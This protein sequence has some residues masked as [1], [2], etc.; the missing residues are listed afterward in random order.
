MLVPKSRCC[1]NFS[2]GIPVQKIPRIPGTGIVSYT[3]YLSIEQQFYADLKKVYFMGSGIEPEVMR[4]HKRD[5][6]IG[7]VTYLLIKIVIFSVKKY[8]FRSF[9]LWNWKSFTCF[10]FYE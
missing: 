6:Q 1:D 7:H 10:K 5:I 9:F 2:P 8:T 3:C 4:A